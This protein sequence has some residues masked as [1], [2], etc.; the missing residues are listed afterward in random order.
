MAVSKRMR[1]EVMRRDGFRCRYCGAD[2][3][4]AE[5]TVDHVTPV[6][7]GGSD[8]P[9]NLATACEPCNSGKTSTT[10]DAPLVADVADDAVRW[11]AAMKQAAANIE[12]QEQTARDYRH[13]FLAEWECWTA[14][15]RTRARAFLPDDW[16]RSI[17]RFR[18]A[19]L[20]DSMW[21]DVVEAA[22]TNR[23][24]SDTSVFRYCCG[25]GWKKIGALQE[26]ARRLLGEQ[27]ADPEPPHEDIVRLWEHAS[28]WAGRRE[29]PI[30]GMEREIVRSQ[31]ANIVRHHEQWGD[32]M[33]AARTA[34]VTAGY[35]NSIVL[36]LGVDGDHDN[37]FYSHSVPARERWKR[38]FWNATHR[39]PNDEESRTFEKSLE[40]V[41]RDPGYFQTFGPLDLFRAADAAG[42]YQDP[43]ISTCLMRKGSAIGAASKPLQPTT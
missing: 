36:H 40:R 33:E 11:A 5:L 12:E 39:W 15:R 17:E 34:A 13:V 8:D 35:F 32:A 30:A 31:V 6:A 23:Q 37:D 18:V 25:I 21:A 22:M 27:D 42:A 4:K 1:Y 41:R 24:V 43:D 3:S 28:M 9:S 26:E 29:D 19:G 2:S 16:K 14:P 20:P 7:L 10:P 38:A